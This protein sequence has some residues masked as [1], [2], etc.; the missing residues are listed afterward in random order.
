MMIYA[1]AV[2]GIMWMAHSLMFFTFLR[3][4]YA[5]YIIFTLCLHNTENWSSIYNHFIIF[6][7][8]Q[9]YVTFKIALRKGH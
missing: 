9:V 6:L 3:E 5:Q 4:K 7:S 1:R 8:P 2:F